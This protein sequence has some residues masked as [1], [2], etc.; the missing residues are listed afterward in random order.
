MANNIINKHNT[1]TYNSISDQRLT[2]ANQLT[3]KSWNDIINMLKTQANINA[4]YLSTLHNWLIGTGSGTVTIPR[5]CSFVEYVMNDFP[6]KV[7]LSENYY[8]KTEVYNKNETYTR[9]EVYTREEALALGLIKVEGYDENT[10]VL[11]IT[12]SAGMYDVDY[13]QATGN[14]IFKFKDNNMVTEEKFQLF[15]ADFNRFVHKTGTEDIDGAKTFLQPVYVAATTPYLIS[16]NIH[17]VGI[18]ALNQDGT[19]FGQVAITDTETDADGIGFVNM[20]YTDANEQGA[21]GKGDKRG[22]RISK[23]RG[24]TYFIGDNHYP[25][26]TL[27]DGKIPSEYLP[28]Y[29]DDVID[30]VVY[31]TRD[32]WQEE[33]NELNCGDVAFVESIGQFVKNVNGETFEYIQPSEGVLYVNTETK[34]LYRW[35]GSVLVAITSELKLGDKSGTAYEG[36]KGKANAEAITRIN[37]TLNNVYTKDEV[38]DIVGS[39]TSEG[40]LTSFGGISAADF[41]I[42]HDYVSDLM[43]GDE[44]VPKANHASGATISGNTEYV[45]KYKASEIESAVDSINDIEFGETRVPYATEATTSGYAL[46]AGRASSVGTEEDVI[47]A[48][49][50]KYAVETITGIMLGDEVPNANVC[51]SANYAVKSGDADKLGNVEASKYVRLDDTNKIPSSYLPSYVDDVIMGKYVHSTKFNAEDGVTELT[52]EAGKIYVDMSTNKTYRWSGFAYIEIS[53]SLVIGTTQGTAFEGSRGSA[54]ELTMTNILDGLQVVPSAEQDAD[55]NVITETYLNKNTTTTQIIKGS[56]IPNSTN[57]VNLGDNTYRFKEIYGALKGT[58]DYATRDGLGNTITTTYATITSL[59]ELENIVDCILGIDDAHEHYTVAKAATATTAGYA[60]KATKD[61]KENIIHETYATKTK[62]EELE[63]TVDC[64]LGLDGTHDHYT[65]MQASYASTAGSAVIAYKDKN[66]K[67]IHETYATIAELDSAKEYINGFISGKYTVAEATEASTAGWSERAQK[68]QNNNIIHETYATKT[69]VDNAIGTN[70]GAVTRAE[71]DDLE[72]TVNCILGL[73][74]EYGVQVVQEASYAKIAGSATKATKDAN[75]K[76]IN[77]HYISKY[78][79]NLT[80]AKKTDIPEASNT[81]TLLTH[82]I[83]E[84]IVLTDPY[85]EYDYLITVAYNYDLSTICEFRLSGALLKAYYYNVLD[86]TL[87]VPISK[88]GTVSSSHVTLTC[89]NRQTSGTRFININPD[90]CY[91]TRVYRMKATDLAY[92]E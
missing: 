92:E 8:N 69:Y 42:N 62:L 48:K 16:K 65:V 90:N 27:K 68:D 34:L 9:T 66:E 87:T 61:E 28:S 31:T 49:D 43:V 40:N 64:I 56:I 37:A 70:T 33:V 32:D 72:T 77:E 3:V 20:F 25:V 2:Y 53:A 22:I 83:L 51:T 86:Y 5:E 52:P 82:G 6:T 50:I 63:N 29:V 12:Y 54:L 26:V 23:K 7:W 58:A 84:Y 80:Y 57:T 10:G 4:T 71:F 18:R 55:F 36:D 91:I 73:D 46:T 15:N 39:A 78:E 85:C 47:E 67:I 79:A 1:V 14:L 21:P 24:F 13:D 89:K 74:T 19:V 75:D 60:T 11:T 88:H 17:K 44:S 38:N 30:F 76:V 59:T 45:G 41:K 81:W 35:S